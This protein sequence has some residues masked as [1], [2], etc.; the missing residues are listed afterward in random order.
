MPS[1]LRRK[2]SVTNQNWMPVFTGMTKQKNNITALL[3]IQTITPVTAS[4]GNPGTPVR[5]GTMSP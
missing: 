3:I 4:P 1:S 2:G 5:T